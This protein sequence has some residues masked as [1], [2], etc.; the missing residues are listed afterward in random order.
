MHPKDVLSIEVKHH[1]A[2][3]GKLFSQNQQIVDQ[4]RRSGKSSSNFLMR[5]AMMETN[6]A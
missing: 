2:M 3:N 6:P 5:V 4:I 1:A